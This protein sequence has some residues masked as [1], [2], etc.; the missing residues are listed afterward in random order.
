[1]Q[2]NSNTGEYELRSETEMMELILSVAKNDE[3]VRAVFLNGSRANVNAPKDRFQDYDIVYLVTEMD[4]FIKDRHWVDAFGKRIIMQEP[5]AMALFP[6]E[7]PGRYAR[8]MLFEDR[9]RIDLSMRLIKDLDTYLKEDKLTVMLLDKDKRIAPL[10][11]P[12]DEDYRVKRPSAEYFDDCCNEF[13]WVSTYVIKGLY[14]KEFFYAAEHLNGNVRPELLRMLSWKVGIET[15]FSVS[16]GKAYKYL[17]K[18]ISADTR[19]QLLKTYQND[20]AEHLMQALLECQD[21]FRK[22][23]RFVAKEF[24]FVYPDYDEKVSAY[25]TNG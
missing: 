13:W 8:L 14:R 23:S 21:L 24:G 25:L 10:P 18:Y 2:Q 19:E 3:R 1:M 11:P 20:S 16:V 15:E 7:H 5:E 6:P 4:S 9:N 22:T 12:S 17:D